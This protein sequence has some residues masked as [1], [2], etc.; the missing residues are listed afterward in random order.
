MNKEKK[1]KKIKKIKTDWFKI[2]ISKLPNT[3]KIFPETCPTR[4]IKKIM[5][6]TIKTIMWKGS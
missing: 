3:K 6:R 2:R 1:L 4:V 5:W